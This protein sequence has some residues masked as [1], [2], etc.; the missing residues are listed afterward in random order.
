MKL[1]LT[2]LALM[3]SLSVH[4]QSKIFP[5]DL[6]NIVGDWK[7]SLTYLDYQTNKPFTMPANLVVKQGKNQYQLVLIKVYPNEPKANSKERLKISKDGFRLNKHV[8]TSRSD[9]ENG[10]LLIQ[11]EY[12]GKDNKKKG[13]IRNSYI[14]GK[15]SFIIRKEVQFDYTDDWIKR[16]EFNYFRK[17]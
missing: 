9:L 3:I 8:V 15:N 1:V 10:Q 6:D 12:K 2:H 7:G 11:T 16:S 14:M 13:L 4:C 17:E 5:A